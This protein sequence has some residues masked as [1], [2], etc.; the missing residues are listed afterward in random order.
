[1]RLAWMPDKTGRLIKVSPK[2]ELELAQAY[3]Q[4]VEPPSEDKPAT[5]RSAASSRKA[6]PKVGKKRSPI[7]PPNHEQTRSRHLVAAQRAE[8]RAK[9]SRKSGD[10]ADAAKWEETARGHRALGKAAHQGRR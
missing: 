9:E 10:A 7:P 4:T 5:H 2:E 3:L 8:K 1:M 6:T